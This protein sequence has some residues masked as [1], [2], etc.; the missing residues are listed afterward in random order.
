MKFL[1]TYSMGM[2]SCPF[3][4]DTWFFWSRRFNAF[5]PNHSLLSFGGLN[6]KPFY[7][8]VTFKSFCPTITAFEGHR[9]ASLGTRSQFTGR[10]FTNAAP[11]IIC[12][13]GT[14]EGGE[15]GHCR[16]LEAGTG[17]AGLERVCPRVSKFG[18]E[19]MVQNRQNLGPQLAL[20]LFKTIHFLWFGWTNYLDT[21][22]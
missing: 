17:S 1:L 3:F 5:W 19:S 2:K 4:T 22:S 14:A 21:P 18:F 10:K 13:L 15:L 6:W 9:K 7:A 12:G 8:E 16:L 20:T 11:K